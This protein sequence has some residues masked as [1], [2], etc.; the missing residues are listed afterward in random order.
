MCIKSQSG[1]T[2]QMKK[3]SLDNF[4]KRIEMKNG[5]IQQ[6]YTGPQVFA[7]TLLRVM[8]GWHFLYEGLV[9]LYTPGWTAKAYLLNSVGPLSAIFKSMAQSEGV[10]NVV[11]T[12]NE[13]G[14]VLIGLGLFIG[15]LSKVCKI[16]GIAL[17]L[18]YYLAYPPFAAFGINPHVEGSYWIVNKTLIEMTALFV[19]FIFSSSHIT[20]LD[21][22]LRSSMK[23]NKK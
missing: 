11:D 10:L 4:D 19:L 2:K 20:G 13:W 5:L 9:K 8:I 14:L 12:L 6:N 16:S 15:L 21:R 22:F 1:G 23:N 18:L 3:Q 17:L 7:L